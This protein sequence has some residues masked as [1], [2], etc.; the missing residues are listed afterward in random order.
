MSQPVL[1][2]VLDRC[3]EAFREA[4]GAASIASELEQ[5]VTAEKLA[6]CSGAFHRPFKLQKMRRLGNK[7]I[8]Q[9]NDVAI[10]QRRI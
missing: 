7:I 10:L 3:E 5:F 8:I 2:A 9:S 6:D 4:R 1:R